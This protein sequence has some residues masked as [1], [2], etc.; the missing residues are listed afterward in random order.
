L[1]LNARKGAWSAQ[2]TLRG[3]FFECLR[4]LFLPHLIAALFRRSEV[5]E[6]WTVLFRET[7]NIQWLRIGATS[8]RVRRRA[9]VAIHNPFHLEPLSCKAKFSSLYSYL[10][11]GVEHL[12]FA[13]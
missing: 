1:P 6:E 3:Y 11:N 13:P 7:Q 5:A 9:G 12:P 2:K 10:S 8:S 4:V